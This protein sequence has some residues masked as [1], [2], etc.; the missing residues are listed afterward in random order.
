MIILGLTHLA[1][2]NQACCI[3]RDGSLIAFAEEERF[4]RIKHAPG[5]FPKNAIQ[6]C[7][8]Y[9][10]MSI[11]D[12]DVV[13]VGFGEKA[14]SELF[15]SAYF[16]SVAQRMYNHLNEMGIPQG[17]VRYYSHHIAHAASTFPCSGYSKGNILSVDGS[18][19]DCAG[20]VG[21]YD[22]FFG[23]FYSSVNLHSKAAFLN[24]IIPA[25]HS[26]GELWSDVT[27]VLGF[28]RHSGEGK[29]M[30]LAP[31]GEYDE[32]ELP[33]FLD[34]KGF[35]DNK[36]YKEFFA[37][38]GYDIQRVYQARP[39]TSVQPMTT[40]GQ[41]IARTLQEYYNR[42]MIQT[43]FDLFRSSGSHTFSI[44]GGC[45][46]NCSGNGALSN[47]PYVGSL[48]VQPAS[49]DAGTA[50]G[51]AVLAH[52][53]ETGK[54]LTTPFDHA[55]WGEEFSCEQI[56]QVLLNQQLSFS[57]VD[58][59]ECA[60]EL[61]AQNY[62]VGF[63]QGRAEIGPRAL[64]NRSILANP[65]FKDNLKRVN[66]IKGRE[67]WRPLSPSI[68]EDDYFDVVDSRHPSPFML[69]A[70]PVRE[71]YLNKIP[72]VVHVDGSCRPQTV[73]QHTNPVYY[74]MINRFKKLTGIPV[75]LNTS[76]N[77]SHEPIVNTPADALS[78]FFS[79]DVDAL[80]M[81]SFLIKKEK[82]Q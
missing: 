73:Y 28:F 13:A 54:P 52:W 62:V 32:S 5:L 78:T 75:V 36:R 17:K 34:A 79:S 43:A 8:T 49:H 56:R 19:E 47:Q 21:V 37:S 76:F 60:A 15:D 41:N 58:P 29:T 48:Y 27:E 55:Y 38:K 26:W 24:R 2:W 1:S 4:I 61:L 71:K 18:G 25:T 80:V 16:E 72:A 63:F 39:K 3:I 65:C 68:L 22:D 7:L 70:V 6:F 50:L 45:G 66:D 20:V 31:Y 81:G 74:R 64:G 12:I 40:K 23:D 9:A 59:A 14:S 82:V 77:L 35:P 67:Y 33:D 44:S 10:G 69:L 42:F 30:G 51:S 57:E 46:L 11:H 53:E